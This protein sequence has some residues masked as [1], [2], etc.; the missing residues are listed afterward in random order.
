[1]TTGDSKRVRALIRFS[2][3]LA[4]ADE[5]TG[6]EVTSREIMAVERRIKGFTANGFFS[7]I[8]VTGLYQIA[9]TAL[10]MRGGLA[11]DVRTFDAFVEAYDVRFK[12]PDEV[13]APAAG[14]EDDETGSEADPTQPT[15]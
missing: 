15:A 12:H 2:Y 4:D 11:P 14:D 6:I 8:T 9:Y 3:A 7:D 1:M 13:A 10:G 5:W